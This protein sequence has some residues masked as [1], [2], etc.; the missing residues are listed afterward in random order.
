MWEQAR[1]TQFNR[2]GD[3]DQHITRQRPPMT[4]LDAIAIISRR[5]R[6]EEIHGSEGPDEYWYRV[7]SGAAKC[8]VV[9]PGGRRQILDL[10]LP[11]DFFGFMPRC[12]HYCT[13]EAVMNGT[14]IASYPR[15][16]AESLAHSDPS[17][18]REIREMT[19]DA[20][21][22]LQELILIL[23]RTT[24][25]EKVGSFLLK[26][27]ERSSKRSV[28]RLSLFVSRYDIADYLALSVETVSRSM[29]DLRD[30][31]FIALAGPRRVKIVDRHG[32]EEGDTSGDGSTVDHA[33]DR[34][35][36]IEATRP[37]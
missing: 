1:L 11:N 37:V 5:N 33:R 26:M 3:Q 9:L 35:N 21:F 28:D 24:A 10:L 8:Y 25:R 36:H 31:G 22:R 17:V 15:R 14:V 29:S 16:R 2:Y 18:G 20:V 27:M 7:I 13:L 6:G 34:R 19:S 32:L 4:G 30:R 12:E 23:G